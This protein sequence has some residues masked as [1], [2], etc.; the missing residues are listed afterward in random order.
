MI[1]RTDDNLKDMKILVS[2]MHEK[3][4][5]SFTG[6][7]REQPLAALCDS[8]LTEQQRSWPE[9]SAGIAALESIRIRELACNGFP[10][11]LQFNPA[12]IISSTAPADPKSIRE[13]PCFLCPGNLPKEQKGVLYRG[14]FLILCN[15]FPI[16]RRHYTVSHVDHIA[17]LL[18]GTIGAFLALAKDFSPHFNVFYNGPR[19]GASA[20]DHLHFQAV[21]VG[22]LP[23]EQSLPDIRRQQPEKYI[24][25]VS[26]TRA[27][28]LGREILVIE[29]NVLDEVGA[30]LLL[31]MERLK[32]S[33]PTSDEPM[34]N[35]LC[36]YR[37]N[38]WRVVMF[39]RRKHR[40]DAYYRKG[41]ERILV[42]PGVV[43]MGGLVITPVE[44]DFLTMDESA[45]EEIYREVSMEPETVRKSM[46]F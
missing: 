13:R 31:I 28:N 40:P 5:A 4:Y 44:K 10:A 22:I 2:E 26:I 39:L 24:G 32:A 16:V 30:A 12:R 9:L 11:K 43:D 17:Q 21:P 27:E 14:M 33:V 36:A 6:E 25:E 3:I 7:G 29:G 20:P 19:S 42:S 34:M 15:P 41:E 37:K 18:A 38:S 35:V 46:S 23:I 8:L 45:L 1:Q